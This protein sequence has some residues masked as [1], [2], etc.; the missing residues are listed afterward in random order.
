[1]PRAVWHVGDGCVQE[2]AATAQLCAGAPDVAAAGTQTEVP[3]WLPSAAPSCS[4]VVA[5]E[6]SQQDLGTSRP[7]VSSV[8]GARGS[9]RTYEGPGSLRPPAQRPPLRGLGDTCRCV[10]CSWEDTSCG[11]ARPPSIRAGWCPPL[12]KTREV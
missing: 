10:S 6:G 8:S 5:A 4:A 3:R 11:R 1:M 9:G 7:R 12:T 2:G